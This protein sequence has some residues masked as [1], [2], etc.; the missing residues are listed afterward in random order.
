MRGVRCLW[1]LFG[2]EI[3]K[4]VEEDE[5]VEIASIH[6]VFMHVAENMVG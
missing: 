5:M 2:V 4:G 3:V 1:Y 6:V